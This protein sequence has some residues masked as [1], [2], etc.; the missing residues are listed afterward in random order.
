LFTANPASVATAMIKLPAAIGTFV[1]AVTRTSWANG[2]PDSFVE[3]RQ[4]M[5]I[6]TAQ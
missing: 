4:M 2:W 5:T 1:R 6:V 3:T